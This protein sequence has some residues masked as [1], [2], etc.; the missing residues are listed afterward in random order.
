M[1]RA[2]TLHVL[3]CASEIPG[4]GAEITRFQGVGSWLLSHICAQGGG[5]PQ[6]AVPRTKLQ[7]PLPTYA[8]SPSNIHDN[9]LT[10]LKVIS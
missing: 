7:Y 4:I 1:T 5:A 9:T 3:L 10:A 6:Y 8:I 2:L